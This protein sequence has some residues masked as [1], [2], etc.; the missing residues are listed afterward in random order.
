MTPPV[1]LGCILT[2]RRIARRS[3]CLTRVTASRVSGS[4]SQSH[5]LFDA[6]AL[7]EGA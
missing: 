7:W 1:G 4:P 5:R 3:S 2:A 6:A